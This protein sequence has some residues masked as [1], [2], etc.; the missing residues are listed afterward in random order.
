M[1]TLRSSRKLAAFKKENCKEHSRSNLAQNAN[2]LRSTEDYIAH[3]SE[4]IG[5]RVT[6]QLSKEFSR[7]ESRILGAL[8]RLDKLLLNPL[9]QSHSGSA[10]ETS[11][12]ALGTKRGT[13]GD[14]SESGPYPEASVSQSQTM[15]NSGPDYGYDTIIPSLP[16]QV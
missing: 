11:R 3:V 9:L 16:L 13:N 14:D 5:G 4:E 10:P 2:V 12:N 6:K 1:A 8:F 7:T 15:L